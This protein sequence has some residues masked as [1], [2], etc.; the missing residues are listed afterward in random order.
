METGPMMTA[1]LTKQAAEVR[2]I[3][4]AISFT[5]VMYW[6]LQDRD[7]FR[8]VEQFPDVQLNELCCCFKYLSTWLRRKYIVFVLALELGRKFC[9][10]YYTV[11]HYRATRQLQRGNSK[12]KNIPLSINT[13]IDNAYYKIKFTI[14]IL[15]ANNALQRRLNF[16]H[17]IIFRKYTNHIL[18]SKLLQH[19]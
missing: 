17:A 7:E 15:I 11:V 4:I 13:C 14:P 5:L 9:L 16:L 2:F 10:N 3:T 6:K 8:S 18:P 19:L 12:I 1:S